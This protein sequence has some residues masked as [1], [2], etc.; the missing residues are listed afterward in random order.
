M[1]RFI[2]SILLVAVATLTAQNSTSTDWQLAGLKGKVKS[3]RNIPYTVE[4]KENKLVKGTVDKDLDSGKI[5]NLDNLQKDFNPKGYLTQMRFYLNDGSLYS[6]MEYYYAPN[7]NLFETRYNSDKTLYAYN[8]EGY[9][10]KDATYSPGGFLK[11]HYAYEVDAK[12][13]VLKEETYQ[14]NELTGSIAYS[15]DKYGN[16]TEMRYYDVEGNLQNR[17]ETKYNKQHLAVRNRTYDAAGKLLNVVR[18]KYNEQGDCVWLESEDRM[19]KKQKNTATYQYSYDLQGN[20]TIKTTFINGEARQI[21]ER[22]LN[23]Y[24]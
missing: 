4:I 9:L 19:P 14:A 24:E 7:G 1:K 21:I 6:R 12:G 23:Y 8:A 18:K 15:Y 3:Q 5:A 13:R 11:R 16:P 17:V 2:T 20:W 10:V 22:T